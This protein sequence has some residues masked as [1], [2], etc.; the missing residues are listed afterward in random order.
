MS[1]F[2]PTHVEISAVCFLQGPSEREEADW[3]CQLDATGSAHQLGH[4]RSPH[5]KNCVVSR[6]QYRT[7]KARRL[8]CQH[9][10]SLDCHQQIQL[11]DFF[12]ILLTLSSLPAVRLVA[13]PELLG[14]QVQLPLALPWCHRWL[15]N[16]ALAW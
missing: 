15:H 1:T 5:G 3:R 11:E 8:H 16:P 6:Q 4:A 9:E 13:P 12:Q 2:P 10:F 7:G 14:H